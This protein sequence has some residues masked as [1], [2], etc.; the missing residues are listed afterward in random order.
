LDFEPGPDPEHALTAED[1]ADAV[2]SV[3]AM[4]PGTVIDEIHLTPLI[5]VITSKRRTRP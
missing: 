3:F 4:R 2:A 5:H 1:V